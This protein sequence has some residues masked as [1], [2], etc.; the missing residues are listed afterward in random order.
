MLKF[1]P[2][3]AR[4][5]LAQQRNDA[6]ERYRLITSAIRTMPDFV[7]IGAQKAGTSFLYAVLAE[8]PQIIPA[9]KKEIHYFDNNYHRGLAWYRSRF[10]YSHTLQWESQKQRRSVYTGEA[11]PYYMFHPYAPQRIAQALPKAKLICVLRN[12]IERAYSHYQHMRRIKVETLSFDDA[13]KQEM[14][15]LDAGLI[16]LEQDE[17]A[18][19]EKHQYLAYIRRGVYIDQLK[20]FETY[21]QA[22]QM[23][24][25]CSEEMFADPQH[26][27]NS[28]T[29]YLGLDVWGL[30]DTS[31]R[32]QGSYEE[33]IKPEILSWLQAYYRR[34][35]E[36]LYTYLGRDFGW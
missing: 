3:P 21:L 29:D 5:L 19:S 20:Q 1:L 14:N 17:F 22:G 35:N 24:I 4:I 32:N 13:L 33:A 8:H 36:A 26:V 6:K 10:P 16:E 18:R 11:T 23:L 30:Q 28:V 25:L 15:R 7:I 27:Y 12:P 2:Q 34:H 9:A 31:P